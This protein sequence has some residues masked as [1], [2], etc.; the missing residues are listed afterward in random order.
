MNRV[1]L[2]HG[3]VQFIRDT[4]GQEEHRGYDKRVTEQGGCKGG[5]PLGLEIGQG[6]ETGNVVE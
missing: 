6:R 2:R 1:V 3:L 4:A 5:R